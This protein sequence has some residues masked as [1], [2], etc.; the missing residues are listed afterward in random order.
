M[1]DFAAL[2]TEKSDG[3]NLLV[4]LW[5]TITISQ[6]FWAHSYSNV[7]VLPFKGVHNYQDMLL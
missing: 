5:G 6:L 2:F 1:N 7:S 4:L 3:W